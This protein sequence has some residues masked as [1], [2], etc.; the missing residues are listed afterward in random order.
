MIV[1]N[2]MMTTIIII[3]WSDDQNH[4]HNDDNDENDHNHD[5]MMIKT[6]FTLT[7][8]MTVWAEEDND[9]LSAHT[10]VDNGQSGGWGETVK[11]VTPAFLLLAP[12][13]NG[14]YNK[15]IFQ[16]KNN[17]IN[18]QE[19]KQTNNNSGHLDLLDHGTAL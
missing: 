15:Q 6:T 7:M 1:L 13:S 18:E 2:M 11:Q 9:D 10:E 16:V 12:P 8:M 14:G 17:K 3:T 4:L 19:N 5:N